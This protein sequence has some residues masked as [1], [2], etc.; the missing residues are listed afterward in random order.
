MRPEPPPARA[1]ARFVLC[2][3][4]MAT[5]LR[6][7][8]RM[9]EACGSRGTRLAVNHQMRF[10]P[11]YTEPKRIVE[12]PA[13][14]GL[15]SVTVVAG[16][17]GLA[18]NGTHYFEM[19]RYMTGE[20]PAWATAWFDPHPVPSPRGPSFEDRAGTVRLTTDSG[21]RF[22]LDASAD[23][24]NGVVV[25]YAGPFGQLIVDELAGS[26]EWLVRAPEHRGLPT[27]RY[28]MPSARHSSNVAPADSVAPTRA[29][30]E[31]LLTDGDV[32]SG[33]DGRLA[34]A[35]LVAAY[36]SDEAGHVSIPIDAALPLERKFPWA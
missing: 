16:N 24:G 22:Y 36:A 3:K 17:L 4:P 20:P 12:S 9:I 28:G 10:M 29:V 1:G 31:A 5:S 25:V 2:E 27:T 6:D 15:S 13:F 32:P 11:Q 8:D 26:L 21:H 14:G 19:F 7:C 18:M 30:L 23:Q 33:E 34:V 35:T